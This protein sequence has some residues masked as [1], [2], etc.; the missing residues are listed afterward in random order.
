[1]CYYLPTRR[2]AFEKMVVLGLNPGKEV[3]GTNLG[4]K[5]LGYR[6]ISDKPNL[7]ENKRGEQKWLLMTNSTTRENGDES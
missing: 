2:V 4:Q 6:I 1:L 3:P 7:E 5:R